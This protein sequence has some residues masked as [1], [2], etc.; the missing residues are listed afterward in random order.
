MNILQVIGTVLVFAM[1]LFDLWRERDQEKKEKK[2]RALNE[3]V[4]GFANDD[5]SA[6][7]RGFDRAN[8]L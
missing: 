7:T 4:K 1:K 8:R 3:V 2:K 6:V 5:L